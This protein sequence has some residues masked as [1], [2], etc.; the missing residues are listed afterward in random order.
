MK[1]IGLIT[2]LPFWEAGNGQN[3]R[4][5]ELVQFLKDHSYFTLF[6]WGK[7]P[8][9]LPAILLNNPEDLRRELESSQLD[10]I[11]VEKLHLDWLLPYLPS[12]IPVYL[13]AHDLVSERSLAFHAHQRPSTGLSCTEEYERLGKFDK[14]IL[15][16]QREVDLAKQWLSQDRLLCC[17]HPTSLSSKPILRT[18]IEHV[19]FL[20]GPS[21]PNIDGIQ[22]F[23]DLV[24]PRLGSLAEKCF[25]NGA[26]TYS[27]FAMFTPHL[28]KGK[29]IASLDHY[30][31]TV[32]IAI[33][34][35]FYGSGLKIKTVEA[36]SYGIPLVTTRNGAEGLLDEADHS[37]LLADTA[38]EFA[39][40]VKRL[41]TSFSLREQLSTRSRKF[42][43][44]HLSP[45]A[46]FQALIT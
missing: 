32:D 39:E 1:K 25:I 29:P 31:Q 5:Q 42:A 20:G 2:D 16:Q 40:A 38:E 10:L 24:I 27:P 18:Q 34:P 28:N 26:I 17:P 12:S 14:V 22:W 7:K 41:A 15:L 3:A 30:Y 44:E 36:L 45:H 23:H 37:F 8:P 46:C 9:P 33:N 6:W 11:I 35:T 13:D 4:I 21:W 19:G 43:Q